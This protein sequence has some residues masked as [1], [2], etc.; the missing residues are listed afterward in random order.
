MN[1]NN[2]NSELDIIIPPEIKNDEFYTIIQKIA[3]E[4]DIKTV[5]EIGSSSG[6]GST[7]AFV[8]GLRENPNQ[9]TL[10][11]MEVSQARF[12]NLKKSYENDSFVKCYNVSSVPIEQFPDQNEI[13]DFHQNSDS[14][15]R[16]Y[17]IEQVLGWLQQ[18]IEYIKNSGVP[19]NGIQQVKQENNIESFDLVLID[20]SEFT[21]I[22]ELKEL[23]GSKFICLD[24][25]TTF[26]NH[27]NH[28]QLLTDPN[29]VLI[30]HN[31]STRNG[32]SVFKKVTGAESI[33][34]TRDNLGLKQ[35]DKYQDIQSAVEAITGF[36]VP[37]QEEYLFNKVKSLPQ[38]AVIVEIGSFQ[39]RSTVAMAYACVDT[40]RKIYSIDTWDGNDSDFSERQ[41]FEIWQQNIQTNNLGQYVLPLRG[42]SHDV[43]EQW[44]KLAT[45]QAIDFIFIDGS[46]QYTDV[47]KDFELSFPLVKDGGWIAFHDVINTWPGPD[48]V[49]HDIAKLRLVNHQYSS[50]L[51][52][53]Q[54]NS[55]AT[56]SSLQ[57]GLPIHFFTIVLNGQPYIPYHIEIFKQLS[58]QWHWHIV[59]GVA[60]LKHDTAWS[61][62]LGG[63]INDDIHRNGLSHDGTTEYLD[64]LVQQYPDNI[65][66]YR[67]PAG[68]FWDGKREMVNAPLANIQE[69]CLLWQVDVDELWTLEQLVTA[70]QLFINNPDKTAAF[71]W[72]SYFVGEKLL[73]STR[74]CYAQNPQQEWLRTWR[75]TP[76]T[77]W[78]AHEPPVLVTPAADGQ[79]Q[80]VAAINPFLH[81]ETEKAGL[82]FQHFAYA[83]KEQ[84]QFKEQYYGY[85]N[86]VSQWGNLQSNTTFPV[87]LRDYFPWVGDHTQVD[88][89]TSREIVPIAQ[90]DVATNTWRFLNPEEVQIQAQQLQE[91]R[92]TIVIDGV[93]FQLFQTGIARVWKSLLEEWSVTSFGKNIIVLDRAGTAPQIPGIRY[94]QIPAFNVDDL[95]GD[96]QMLQSICDEEGADV[97]TSTYYTTPIST[98]SVL[99][100]YDLIP[101]VLGW[102]LEHPN[103]RGKVQAIEQASAYAS[104]S[105]NSAQDLMRFYPSTNS[106]Q[107]DVTYCGVS[108]K[109]APVSL[110]ELQAFQAKYGIQKPYFLITSGH[111][112]YKNT[113]LFFK[114]FAKLINSSAFDIVCTS[115]LPDEYRQFTQGSTV[116]HMR[117]SDEGLRLAYAGA[118]A[119]IYPSKYEGFGLPVIEA[120]ACGCPV[121][122]CPTASLPEVAGE[123]ALYV[124]DEDVNGMTDALCEIQKPSVRQTLINKGLAQ[125]QKFSWT[126]MARQ[127]GDILVNVQSNSLPSF[128]LQERNLLMFPD[129][130]VDEELLSQELATAIGQ[131]IQTPDLDSTALLL[132]VSSAE[133]LEQVEL[134][135]A[136][137]SMNLLMEEDVDITEYLEISPIKELSIEQWHEL[138]PRINNLVS[139]PHEAT[140]TKSRLVTAGLQLPDTHN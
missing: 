7:E 98:P 52:C 72:C 54:K 2:S 47:L 14:N 113:I 100:I 85:K 56:T 39:G 13:I 89:A 75:F 136:G 68:I 45:G 55:V 86:A 8:I 78:A 66:I 35:P 59:E 16:A 112:G 40:N 80:N 109:F 15:L 30:S 118:V 19:A 129:W 90:R 71:Y 102:D 62:Q 58:C 1:S 87:F 28:H 97:F 81:A 88:I 32:Y 33:F 101:E 36:M 115:D 77:L 67:K 12:A 139:L 31:T 4:E 93:F 91:S 76:G 92:P 25:I 49:W 130:S 69:E 23:Y 126:K 105:E 79:Y 106:R 110:T 27:Q 3:R 84:L 44:Q 95:D 123:A 135:L 18:D 57:S 140:I 137:I 17:P 41:F 94:R 134:I 38:D 48:R 6:E 24:D 124:Q 96:R 65:T 26:K 10:F 122:T 37:G 108:D 125:A 70:K 107:I 51:A 127:V 83:T 104:I 60:D 34:V 117:L 131:L 9:P 43:L 22:A 64:A 132:D 114:A 99:M 42:Y 138:L 111:D 53:G 128:S 120:L 11:C 5:L 116:H 61:V 74:N 29:Y 73:I 103:W 50:S 46:H 82:V 20:G 119:L 63:A 133:S 21:G 121:I